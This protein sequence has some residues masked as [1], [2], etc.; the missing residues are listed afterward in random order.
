MAGMYVREGNPK[1]IRGWEDLARK[2]VS[3]V[4]RERGS[5]TRV[6]LDEHLRKLGIDPQA[7]QGYHR[8]CLTHLAAA[9]AVARGGADIAIGCENAMLQVR[10]L[11]FIP[12]QKERY[13]LVIKR[14]NLSKPLFETAIRIVRSAEFREEVSSFGGYDVTE[15][16]TIVAET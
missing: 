9:G 2:D 1:G 14:E 10:G 3:I 15:T 16:G 12:L 11:E 8:E 4:N 7:I 13:E 5:G 6:L